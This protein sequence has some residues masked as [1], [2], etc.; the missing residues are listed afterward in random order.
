MISHEEARDAITALRSACTRFERNAHLGQ[1]IRSSTFYMEAMRLL[2][3]YVLIVGELPADRYG[4]A[5]VTSRVLSLSKHSGLDRD[6]LVEEINS[7]V[8]RIDL[9]TAEARRTR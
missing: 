4:L 6:V 2:R 7:L 3:R 1:P 5:A 8:V 9:A